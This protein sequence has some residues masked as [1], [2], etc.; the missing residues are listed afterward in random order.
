MS[1]KRLR[2]VHPAVGREANMVLLEAI[3]NAKPDLRVASPIYIHSVDGGYT[4]QIA[5]LYAGG[6]LDD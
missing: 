4:T 6:E 1:K 5:S 3:K 2:L